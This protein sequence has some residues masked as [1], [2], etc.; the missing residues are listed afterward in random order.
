MRQRVWGG[1]RLPPCPP[2]NDPNASARVGTGLRLL[3]V[4]SKKSGEARGRQ[5]RRK[6]VGAETYIRGQGGAGAPA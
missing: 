5:E 1:A 3:S 2:R 6:Y 4:V